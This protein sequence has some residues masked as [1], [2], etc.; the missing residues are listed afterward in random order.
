[1]KIGNRRA[2]N[3]STSIFLGLA[4][5]A[6]TGCSLL[7]AAGNTKVLWAINEPA[8]MYV[9]V[10][11]ADIAAV[12][13]KEVDR[14][15]T[16]TPTG[17]DSTWMAQVGPDPKVAAG[18]M[19]AV[20]QDPLYAS[21]HARVL[22]AE[23]WIRTLPAVQSTGGDKPNLLA[24]IDPS[25]G[26][27]YASIMAKKQEIAT[28][29]AKVDEEKAAAGADGVSAEDKK[30]HND[31]ADKAKA[32]ESKAKDEVDPLAKKFLASVKDTAAKVPADQ[33]AKFAPAV[34]NLLQAL[35]DADLANSAAAV[36]YPLAFPKSPGKLMD[37]V[38]AAVPYIVADI[39][40]EKT[41]VRPSFTKLDVQVTLAGGTV[42]VVLNGIGPNEM[43][44][45]N[46]ADVTKETIS[47]TTKWVAHATTL[48]GSVASTKEALSF[49]HDVLAG[50]QAGFAPPPSGGATF[51][52]RI[53]APDSAEVMAAVPAVHVKIG[54]AAKS[55]PV[56]TTAA[57]VTKDAKPKADAKA[58]AGKKPG[59]KA[60][61]KNKATH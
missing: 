45:L 60:P 35:D 5:S 43:G 11:R 58:G 33:Q 18:E 44:Q 46:M 20:S 8:P 52:V 7:S 9:V 25:L 41:G 40:E 27:S 48:L 47:R 49:E 14:L 24:A 3:L 16:A 12:T 56:V 21:S 30:A 29:E 13:T 17:A 36:R 15:L 38:K 54:A 10:R 26:D 37:E 34:A 32:D 6:T 61:A 57:V 22:A 31:A 39:I 4:L 2:F 23:V 51:L 28:L 1:M 50:L 42:T 19:K 53:P 59:D 55:A